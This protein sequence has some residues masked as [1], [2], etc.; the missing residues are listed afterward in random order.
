LRWAYAENVANFGQMQFLRPNGVGLNRKAA[1]PTAATAT[2]GRREERIANTRA[3]TAF[4]A[5]PG[6]AR[7]SVL[8]LLSFESAW[9]CRLLALSGH[10]RVACECPLSADQRTSLKPASSPLLTQSGHQRGPS[11]VYAAG[12]RRRGDR[13]KRREFIAGL[14]GAA[15][16]G[17]RG[18]WGA[19]DREASQRA[20]PAH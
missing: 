14:G 1:S 7:Q 19:A 9:R 4:A 8:P 11:G 2:A 17:P 13:M 15:V 16:M 12:R 18:A 10:R 3:T 6:H 20:F 5:C